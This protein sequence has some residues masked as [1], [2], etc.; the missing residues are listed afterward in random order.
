M[1]ANLGYQ[2]EVPTKFQPNRTAHGWEIAISVIM[3]YLFSFFSSQF[4]SL[5]LFF[6]CSSAAR[7]LSARAYFFDDYFWKIRENI[8]W[9]RYVTKKTPIT[10]CGR[11]PGRRPFWFAWRLKVKKWLPFLNGLSDLS[12]NFCVDILFSSCFQKTWHDMSCHVLSCPVMSCHFFVLL[13]TNF[14]KN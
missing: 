8:F 3:L 11:R 2:P 10:P 7:G 14:L 4:Q 9:K 6:P 13:K 1:Q 5:P 12:A